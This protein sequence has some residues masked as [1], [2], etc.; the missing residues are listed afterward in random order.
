MVLNLLESL[1]LSLLESSAKFI[2]RAQGSKSKNAYK[3]WEKYIHKG[4]RESKS[5]GIKKQ[6]KIQLDSSLLPLEYILFPLY[7]IPF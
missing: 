4:Y 6:R 2:S 7:N 5:T 3:N 1:V